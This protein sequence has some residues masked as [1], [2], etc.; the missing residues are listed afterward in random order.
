MILLLL[1]NIHILLHSYYIIMLFII[2][3][4]LSWA[5]LYKVLSLYNK[6]PQI[7]ELKTTIYFIHDSVGW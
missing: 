4:A 6:P 3:S 1:S 2:I 5:T 7:L